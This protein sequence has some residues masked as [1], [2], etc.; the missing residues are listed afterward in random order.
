MNPN[1]ETAVRAALGDGSNPYDGEIPPALK[2]AVL[3]Y[4]EGCT[5]ATVVPNRADIVLLVETT[6]AYEWVRKEREKAAKA[7]QKKAG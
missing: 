3:R 2:A 6:G 5:R 4:Y 7:E 1:A